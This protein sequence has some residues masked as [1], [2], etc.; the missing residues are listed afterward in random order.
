MVTGICKQP[1]VHSYQQGP[2]RGPVS[3]DMSKGPPVP[4]SYFLPLSPLVARPGLP[5]RRVYSDKPVAGRFPH[6]PFGDVFALG[7]Q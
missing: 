2:G 3:Q 6:I 5:G 4:S 7:P 1:P